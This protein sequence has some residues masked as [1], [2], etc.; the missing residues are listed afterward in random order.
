MKMA[1]YEKARKRTDLNEGGWGNNPD[2]KGGETYRGIARNFW[3]SWPGWAIVDQVKKANGVTKDLDAQLEAAPGL[4]DLVVAFYKQNFWDPCGLDGLHDDYAAFLVYDA[5]VNIG[6][7]VK[8]WIQKVLNVLNNRQKLWADLVV[9][10]IIGAGT[11]VAWN[12][13]L[14]QGTFRDHFFKCFEALRVAHYIE[15]S[16]RTEAFEQFM[17][18]WLIR[19]ELNMQI[20]KSF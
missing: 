5:F 3:G 7:P 4:S 16:T 6:P 1:N 9:D 13:C 17:E 14:S 19:C 2:D 20:E 15:I 18:G 10:G 8:L 11:L 12:T